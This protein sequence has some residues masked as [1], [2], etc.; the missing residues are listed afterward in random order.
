[1]I[2]TLAKVAR[3]AFLVIVIL[4]LSGWAGRGACPLLPR[5]AGAK[6]PGLGLELSTRR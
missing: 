5:S 2:R 6:L 3:R 1:M 4:G